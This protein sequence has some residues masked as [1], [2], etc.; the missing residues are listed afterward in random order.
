MK[1]KSKNIKNF[2]HKSYRFGLY[3]PLSNLLLV[4]GEKILPQ[5]LLDFLCQSRN[6]IIE[7]KVRKI[8]GEIKIEDSQL[9][10]TEK[11]KIWMVWFSGEETLPPLQKMCV[12]SV[13]RNSNGH[14]VVMIT[15]QNY[16]QYIDIPEKILQLFHDGILNP[17]NLADVI[18]IR[19][20][21]R[22]GGF[23]ID[24][25]VYVTEP[26]SEKLFQ[27]TLYS[28]KQKKDWFYVSECRWT[29]FCFYMNKKSLLPHLVDAMLMKYWEKETYIIDYFLFDYLIDIAIHDYASVK[30]D[31]D[32]IPMNN[33]ELNTLCP[34]LCDKFDIEEWDKMQAKTT[35]FKLSWKVF[36]YEQLN[37][38][39]NNYY[40]YLLKSVGK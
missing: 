15:L 22:Y 18:R 37:A 1:I 12:E 2:F 16:K 4:H 34:K 32:A 38:D 5:R 11:P 9:I 3:I 10:P 26:I 29:G 30:N 39:D 40:N 31:I 21:S 13:R 19:L 7:N 35:F 14:D 8:V 25:T 27:S 6:K 33:P 24:S 17:A 23:W 28:L 20:L 36:S